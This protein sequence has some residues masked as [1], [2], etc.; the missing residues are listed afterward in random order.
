[1]AMPMPDFNAMQMQ[2]FQDNCAFRAGMATVGGTKT[3]GET[4]RTE[5]ERVKKRQSKDRKKRSEERE[6]EATRETKAIEKGNRRGRA[7]LMVR[8]KQQRRR[9]K[10]WTRRGSKEDVHVERKKSPLR[11]RAGFI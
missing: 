8:A 4:A 10:R 11:S 5:R 3:E 1:M 9:Q 6:R 7:V 2:D